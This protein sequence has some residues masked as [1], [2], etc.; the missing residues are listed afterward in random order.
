MSPS[1]TLGYMPAPRRSGRPVRVVVAVALLVAVVIA[2]CLFAT[3]RPAATVPAA[4]TAAAQ[5]RQSLEVAAAQSRSLVRGVM[6]TEAAR[7]ADAKA[8]TRMGEM[9]G[10]VDLPPQVTNG[11]AWTLR[12]APPDGWYR[13]YAHYSFEQGTNVLFLKRKN[14]VNVEHFVAVDMT[15]N[16]PF[17]EFFGTALDPASPSLTSAIGQIGRRGAQTTRLAEFSFVEE[18]CYVL[19]EMPPQDDPSRCAFRVIHGEHSDLVSVYLTPG[20]KLTASVTPDPAA[21]NRWRLPTREPAAGQ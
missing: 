16:G 20:G 3:R 5:M 7:R 21:E 18:A 14:A 13:G 2:G 15:V 8:L 9:G 4:P 12:L 17:L 11:V 19:A 6:V 1:H 10:W